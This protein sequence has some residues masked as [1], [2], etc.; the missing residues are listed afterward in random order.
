MSSTKCTRNAFD[1]KK[2]IKL[3]RTYPRHHGIDCGASNPGK[4]PKLKTL[5]NGLKNGS[6]GR[7]NETP[8]LPSLA[9]LGFES[10]I[11]PETTSK[12]VKKKFEGQN[13]FCS[14]YKCSFSNFYYYSNDQV[15]FG[16]LK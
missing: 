4:P 10:P 5:K 9:M 7:W 2:K 11:V 6:I 13:C 15:M 8:E 3:L 12:S 1:S 16:I 14:K